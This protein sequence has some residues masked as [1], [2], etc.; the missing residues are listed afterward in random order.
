MLPWLAVSS[1]HQF[2]SNG[3]PFPD[4]GFGYD[5]VLG[6]AVSGRHLYKGTRSEFLK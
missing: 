3:C 5:I 4:S 6:W 1:Y 2:L